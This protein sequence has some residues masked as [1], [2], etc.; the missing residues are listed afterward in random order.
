MN[1]CFKRLLLLSFVTLV[2]LLLFL[3]LLVFTQHGVRHSGAEFHPSSVELSAGSAYEAWGES[4]S[5]GDGTPDFLRLSDP[6]D[7]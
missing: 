4:D 7:R 5:F 1:A 2:I 6:A 3:R